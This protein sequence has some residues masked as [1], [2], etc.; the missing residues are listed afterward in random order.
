MLIS[1]SGIPLRFQLL[2]A[3]GRSFI[4]NVQDTKTIPLGLRTITYPVG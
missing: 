2:N 1:F 3:V 4:S